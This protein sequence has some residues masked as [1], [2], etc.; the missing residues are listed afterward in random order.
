MQ[1][2]VL[3][4]FSSNDHNSFLEDC[5]IT[6]IDKNRWVWSHDKRRIVL[7][8]STEDCYSLW[9]EHDRLIALSGQVAS[10]YTYLWHILLAVPVVYAL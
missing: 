2:L 6:L 9:V 5:S 1:P 8:K 4:H 10:S 3:E 7:E